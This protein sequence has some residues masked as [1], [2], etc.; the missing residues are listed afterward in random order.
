MKKFRGLIF[1]LGYMLHHL[2]QH[3]NCHK[4][5]GKPM[6]QLSEFTV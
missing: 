6:F 5:Q 3:Q 2:L 4:I 1:I